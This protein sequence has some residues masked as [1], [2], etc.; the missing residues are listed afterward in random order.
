MSEGAI[1]A[2]RRSCEAAARG[3]LE[4]AMSDLDSGVEIVDTD[5]P[6][7]GSYRGREGYLRWLSQWSESWGSWSLE[8]F[9]YREAPDGRV[10]VLF[11]LHTTGK[12]SGV[13]LMRKDAMVCNV[14]DGKLT[15]IVY[16]NDQALALDE[17]GLG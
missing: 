12:G 14:R 4:E 9:E 6:D 3:D 8:G 1:E 2:V 10:V 17:A 7:A 15:R 13:E 16:F 5:I 11:D